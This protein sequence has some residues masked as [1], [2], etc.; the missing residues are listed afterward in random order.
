[1]VNI[2]KGKD[3]IEHVYE[4]SAILVSMGINNSMNNGF[5]YDVNINF[6][7]VKKEESDLS[8]Y[9]DKRKYG[10]ILLINKYGLQF[11]MCYMA[12]NPYRK[13]DDK[14]FLDYGHLRSCLK[15]VN[16]E[17]SGKGIKI[18]STILGEKKF[19]GNG[20]RDKIIEIFEECLSVVDIDLYDYKQ[21]NTY[22]KVHR[23][24][25]ELNR[26]FDEKLIDRDE[27]ERIMSEIEWRR[28][29]GIYV[30]MPKDYRYD[31]NERWKKNVISL[32]KL[33]N[34]EKN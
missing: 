9:G 1:M 6:P 34:F 21:E 30:K 32:K 18:A 19:E 4:Y 10:D 31:S 14:P 23:E 25:C 13:H 26:K 11:V 12:G 24:I 7:Y 33:K 15:K 27:Y 28:M 16:E 5:P 17:F 20:D 29:H 3:L 8:P 2:I 22:N